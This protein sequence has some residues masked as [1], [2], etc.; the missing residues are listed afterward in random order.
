M[1]FLFKI[2]VKRHS[3]IGMTYFF[4]D[5]FENLYHYHMYLVYLEFYMD[6]EDI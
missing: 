2:P 3:K 1:S 5:K 4:R 6:G